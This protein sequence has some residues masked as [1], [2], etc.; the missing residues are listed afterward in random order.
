LQIGAH[1]ILHHILPSARG[2]LTRAIHFTK[3]RHLPRGM[4]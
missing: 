3:R 1:H 4:E 2:L